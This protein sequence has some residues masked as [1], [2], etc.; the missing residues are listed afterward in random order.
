MK[1]TY[2][3]LKDWTD[4]TDQ[5]TDTIQTSGNLWLTGKAISTQDYT[6]HTYQVLP[7]GSGPTW[8]G[9]FSV[10]V[11]NDGTNYTCIANYDVLAS[12][13]GIAYSDIWAFAYARPVMTGTAG[14]FLINERHLS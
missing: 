10:E 4:R 11:S 6:V 14:E 8:D 9:N 7:I 12:N 1:K 2:R 5:G 3:R 13:S